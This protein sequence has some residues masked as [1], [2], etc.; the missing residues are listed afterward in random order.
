MRGIPNLALLGAILALGEL[1]TAAEPAKVEATTEVDCPKISAAPK[2]DG[3]L[4]DP[5][6]EKAVLIDQFPIFWA[7]KP[8]PGT[9]KARLA[10]DDEAL[11]FAAEME[12]QELRTAGVKNNDRLWEGDVFEVFLKP[13]EKRP[14]Y[15]EFHVNLKSLVLELAFPKRGADFNALAALPS[16]GMSAMAV[17]RGTVNAPGDKDQGWTAEGRIPWAIFAKTGGRPQPGSQ[18]RFALC[19]YDYGKDGTQ[20]V[21]VSSA[22]LTA[23][24]FHRYEDFGLI[25]FID[26]R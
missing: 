4:D 9:T 20:P 21:L 1:A 26:A 23:P 2:I 15:F 25:R 11:Y 6:W 10:W 19:R 17:A 18:W 13:D 5:A 8:G 22:P 14:E 16:L 12:D 3:K 7:G 24:N